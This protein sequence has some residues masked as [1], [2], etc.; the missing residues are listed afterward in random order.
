MTVVMERTEGFVSV[1]MQAKAFSYFLNGGAFETRYFMLFYHTYNVKLLMVCEHCRMAIRRAFG[2]E[3]ATVDTAMLNRQSNS[4][5]RFPHRTHFV[6]VRR[7][8]HRESLD[9]WRM[10]MSHPQ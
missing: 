3:I 6:S 8:P 1:D 9:I 2:K 5:L 10:Q 4:C 7:G